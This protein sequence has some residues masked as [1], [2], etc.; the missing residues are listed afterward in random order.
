[1]GFVPEFDNGTLVWRQN[2]GYLD[3]NDE[4]TVLVQ[5]NHDET[6]GC[7]VINL[8][9]KYYVG[10]IHSVCKNGLLHLLSFDHS[11]LPSNGLRVDLIFLIL[12]QC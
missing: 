1:M 2:I 12:T 6:L 7:D 4:F 10:T 8:K 3:Y 9:S 5:P 11:L